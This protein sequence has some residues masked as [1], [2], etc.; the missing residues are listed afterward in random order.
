MITQD[1]PFDALIDELGVERES[2]KNPLFQ[3]LFVVQNAQLENMKDEF[4]EW[5]L[6]IMDSDTS[7]FDFIAQ[8]FEIG[9]KLS[10]KFEYDTN[11]FLDETIQRWS[12]HFKLLLKHIL[13][14]LT[15]EVGS[16]DILTPQERN[17]I[18]SLNATKTDYAVDKNI[19]ELFEETVSRVPQQTAVSTNDQRVTYEQLREKV[20]R[21]AMHLSD[22]GIRHRPCCDC[23][24]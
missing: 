6:T 15:Q 20:D 16:F 4:A 13:T 7:K 5:N 3:T 1:V 23:C 24:R 18:K 8:V 2:G 14:D 19:Y 21:L 11:L 22:K 10:V 12:E 17:R 9:N